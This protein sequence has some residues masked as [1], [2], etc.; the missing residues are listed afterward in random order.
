[1]SEASGRGT[2]SSSAAADGPAPSTTEP[3]AT[4]PVASLASLLG[5]EF[6]NGAACAADGTCD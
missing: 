3:Q 2:T 4:A 5:G 1:M 6:E